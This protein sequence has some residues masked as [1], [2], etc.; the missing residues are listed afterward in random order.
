MAHVDNSSLRFAFLL[1]WF[2]RLITSNQK[3]GDVDVYLLKPSGEYKRL[4]A[5]ELLPFGFSPEDLKVHAEEQ[6]TRK[7]IHQIEEIQVQ[8]E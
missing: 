4:R 1:N 7:W 3:F 6:E 5:K 2:R 8:Q